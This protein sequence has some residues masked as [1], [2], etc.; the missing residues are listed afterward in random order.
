MPR[1]TVSE[2]RCYVCFPIDAT[3]LKENKIRYGTVFRR[4]LVTVQQCSF[5]CENWYDLVTSTKKKP[6]AKNSQRLAQG[7]VLGTLL[8]LAMR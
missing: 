3:A 8:H 7:L 4:F 6:P 2:T 5:V 1:L